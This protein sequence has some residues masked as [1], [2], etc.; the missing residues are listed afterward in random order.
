[1]LYAGKGRSSGVSPVQLLR[2]EILVLFTFYSSNSIITD[3]FFTFKA[4]I[5]KAI[6]AFFN[7]YTTDNRYEYKY[8]EFDNFVL[9]MMLFYVEED[10]IKRI[11]KTHNINKIQIAETEKKSFI[12]DLGNFFT[13]QVANQ[14]YVG[15]K[16]NEDINKQEYFSHYRQLLRHIF[17]RAMLI[18]SRAHL[19][20]EELI[21]ITQPFIDFLSTAEDVS[22]SSWEYATKFLS[23]HIQAFDDMQ[24]KSIIELTLS[25]KHN[26]NGDSSL[27]HI[28]DFANEKSNFIISDH[29]FF[30]K[31]LNLLS[32]PSSTNNQHLDI[33]KIFSLWNVADENGKLLIKQKAVEHLENKFDPELYQYGVFTGAFNR[34]E[35]TNLLDQY[36]FYAQNACHEFDLKLEK[37]HWIFHSFAGFNCLNCL[38]LL[39]IDFTEDRIQVIAK[40]SEYYNWLVNYDTYDYSN[41]DCSWLIDAC[42]FHLKMKINKVESLKK[43]VASELSKDYNPELGAFYIKYL[44][45]DSSK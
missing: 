27:E 34:F 17:N 10:S 4:T 36:I 45:N 43:K 7:S 37:G 11:F 9:K 33:T 25:D 15:L 30:L 19:S 42:P 5:T 38:L 21:P 40:K 14:K 2:Q 20:C 32:T 44:M 29:I 39:N 24:I 6:E 22:H 23:E 1:M 12:R 41:F 26:R 35:Y 3:D 18:L 28:C 31:I 8:K 13:S 16:F